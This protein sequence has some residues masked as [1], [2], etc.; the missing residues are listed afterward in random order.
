MKCQCVMPFLAY[1]YSL[2]CCDT[3]HMY[4]EGLILLHHGFQGKEGIATGLMLE[5]IPLA[6]IA[7]Y[8]V[9]CSLTMRC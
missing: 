3:L 4:F 1:F 8:L 9:I 7:S 6:D 2:L 5:Q